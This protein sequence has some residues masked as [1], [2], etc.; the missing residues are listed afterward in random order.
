MRVASSATTASEDTTETATSVPYGGVFDNYQAV[1]LS[2]GYGT[3][4]ANIWV[5]SPTP[6]RKTVI[7]DTGSHYTAFPCSGCLNWYVAQTRALHGILCK[8]L[9]YCL[10]GRERCPSTAVALIIRILTLIPKNPRRFGFY[11]VTSVG[12]A[13][14]ATMV[15]AAS[16]SC[17]QKGVAGRLFRWKIDS[18]VAVPTFWIALIRAIPSMPL[19]SCLAVRPP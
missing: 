15:N 13:F 16:V 10:I 3:H 11:S 5:G 12:M 19:I 2:Q 9:T 8:P 14:C 7:V 6:Q 4:F 17:T 18:T 1:P